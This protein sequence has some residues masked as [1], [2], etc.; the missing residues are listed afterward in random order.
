M[1]NSFCLW[2]SLFIWVKTRLEGLIMDK[3]RAHMHNTSGRNALAECEFW[4]CVEEM[5][6]SLP[7]VLKSCNCE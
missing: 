2:A 3:D 1:S 7:C 5:I 6:S 4:S